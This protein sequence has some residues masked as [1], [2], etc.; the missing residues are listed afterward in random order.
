MN[1][2]VIIIALVVV[3]LCGIVLFGAPF[4]PTKRA[5]IAAALE[6]L[7]LK[8]GQ[9]LYD[10]GAGDGRVALAAAKKGWRVV[11]YEL[12]IF[13]FLVTL[14][15]TRKYRRLVTVRLQ[16][17]WQADFSKCDGVYIFSSSRYMKRLDKKLA[18]AKK[19][20]KLASF[21]FQIIGKKYAE[22]K[23][24]IFLYHY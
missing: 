4:V 22:E 24:G 23:D 15:R 1:V 5:Q 8:K 9:L 16:S 10:L 11:G 2:F 6:L 12:N 19:G 14:F 7:D 3:L 13:L 17:Y 20:T 21:A 18:D